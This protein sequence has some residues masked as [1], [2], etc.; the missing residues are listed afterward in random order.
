[1]LVRDETL[2][3][4][5]SIVYAGTQTRGQVSPAASMCQSLS[6]VLRRAGLHQEKDL[7]PASVAFWAGRQAFEAVDVRNLE[8]A[9]VAMGLKSLDLTAQKIDYSWE[10]K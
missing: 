4:N 10:Q 6:E 8:A 1:M 2:Q 7:R 3:L 5:E 9:A